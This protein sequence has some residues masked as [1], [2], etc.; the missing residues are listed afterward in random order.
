MSLY[1]T[2]KNPPKKNDFSKDLPFTNG[3]EIFLKYVLFV[4]FVRSVFA[5]TVLSNSS[6]TIKNMKN[7]RELGHIQL[8]KRV[9]WSRGV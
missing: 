8:V 7:L 2:N 4:V 9:S 5:K 3:F 1:N 6:L